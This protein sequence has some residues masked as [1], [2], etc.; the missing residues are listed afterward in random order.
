MPL[1]AHQL[2]PIRVPLKQIAT[3]IHNVV[4]VVVVDSHISV[5][6]LQLK[7]LR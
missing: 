3:S 7:Q 5:L 4:V 1:I 6:S 2:S